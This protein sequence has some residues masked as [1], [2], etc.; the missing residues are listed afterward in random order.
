VTPMTR[1]ARVDGLRLAYQTVGEGA[2]D[3]VLADQWTSRQEAH[4]EV[5]RRPE[6]KCLAVPTTSFGRPTASGKT[7][8]GG[9]LVPTLDQLPIRAAMV[10]HF[11]DRSGWT[12]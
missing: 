9:K 11:L 4:W 8:T 1:Y 3:I 10:T 12:S 5:P 7:M 6:V 2:I